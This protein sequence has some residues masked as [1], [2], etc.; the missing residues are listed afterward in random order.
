MPLTADSTLS[1]GVISTPTDKVPEGM[2]SFSVVAYRPRTYAAKFR[3]TAGDKMHDDGWVE[4]GTMVYTY[5]HD[6][7]Q[8]LTDYM[9]EVI[10]FPLENKRPDYDTLAPKFFEEFIR[11]ADLEWDRIV[12]ERGINPLK[13]RHFGGMYR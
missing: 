6:A 11:L 9:D 8:K 12:A 1:H 7:T 5:I 3:V 10:G 2:K 4:Y 13:A